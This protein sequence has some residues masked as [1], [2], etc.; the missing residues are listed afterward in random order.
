M[1]IG[2][3]NDREGGGRGGET[4]ENVNGQ[5]WNRG[6][7]STHEHELIA[8]PSG[9]SSPGIPVSFSLSCRATMT[10]C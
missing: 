1:I 5:L 7:E 3:A 8:N 6:R 2:P 9:K 4:L 10:H